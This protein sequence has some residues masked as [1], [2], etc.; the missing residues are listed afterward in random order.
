VGFAATTD[1]APRRPVS[2]HYIYTNFEP[3]QDVRA[4]TTRSVDVE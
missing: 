3:N 1:A 4:G 2:D